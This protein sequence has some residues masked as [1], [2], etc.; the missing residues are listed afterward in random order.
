MTDRRCFLVHPVPSESEPVGGLAVRPHPYRVLQ[1]FT[2]IFQGETLHRDSLGNVQATRPGQVNQIAAG[3]G[4][5]HSEE[6]T[7]AGRHCHA[8]PLWIAPFYGLLSI[9][10]CFDLLP[11]LL[12]LQKQVLTFTL[13]LS[14]RQ[15]GMMVE[16]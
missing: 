2:G 9:T 3:H 16:G 7:P 6:T 13:F 10:P 15:F 4:I 11:V 1:T 14:A 5:S 8:A 12:R